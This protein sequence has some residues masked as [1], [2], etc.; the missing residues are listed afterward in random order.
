MIPRQW[1]PRNIG[2]AGESA[3]SAGFAVDSDSVCDPGGGLLSISPGFPYHVLISS[4]YCHRAAAADFQ[5]GT[6]VASF[7]I[8]PNTLFNILPAS[9]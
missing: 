5:L 4:W 1:G 9:A 3:A 8:Q 7:K 6:L 2:P